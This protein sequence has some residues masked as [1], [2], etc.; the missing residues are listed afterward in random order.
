MTKEPNERK[1]SFSVKARITETYDKWYPRAEACVTRNAELLEK[2]NRDID[3]TTDPTLRT[4]LLDL[5]MTLVTMDNID[6]KFMLLLNMINSLTGV[7]DIA[8][9][10]LSEEQKKHMVALAEQTER[11]RK[12]F[13]EHLVKRLARLFSDSGH[14]AMYGS[15]ART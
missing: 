2:L 4:Q 5:R 14:E 3:E 10:E 15:G 9:Q 1:N 13:D 6:L 12:E 11:A 7:L 8:S